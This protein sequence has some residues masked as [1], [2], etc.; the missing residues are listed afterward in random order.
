MRHMS[1][2]LLSSL[3]YNVTDSDVNRNAGERNWN[4]GA[5]LI[6]GFSDSLR[7]E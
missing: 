3:V 6:A 1:F 2:S 4:A 5:E 7:D